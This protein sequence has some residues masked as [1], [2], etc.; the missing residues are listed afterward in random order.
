MIE[1]TEVASCLRR[2]L[3]RYFKD[4]DG[5]EPTEIYSMVLSAVEKP[6]LIYIL[7]RADGNQTRAADILGINRNTLRKKLREHGLSD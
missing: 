6:L 3:N 1:E 5:E 2:A 7:D 4:L